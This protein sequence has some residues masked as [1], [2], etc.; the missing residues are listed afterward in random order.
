MRAVRRLPTA[1]LAV[2]ALAFAAGC[3]GGDDDT[4][5][6]NAYVEQLNAAQREFAATVKRLDGRVS[7]DSSPSQDRATL[8]SF[9][10]AADE[11]AVEVR[12]IQAP[13]AV[14]RLHAG[15]VDDFETYADEVRSATRSL[16]SRDP[17]R[18]I[19]AQQ[20]LLKATD[21]VTA[22]INTAIDDINAKLRS[23]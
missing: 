15:L 18:V 20:R 5:Q 10:E 13:D 19:A 16:T 11:V 8:G 6:G 17:D 22:E 23:T 14:Q 1:L 2:L 12:D 9:T 21:T 3:G 4:E 7:E